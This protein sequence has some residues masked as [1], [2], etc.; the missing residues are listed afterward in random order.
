M[1]M[2]VARGRSDPWRKTGKISDSVMTAYA[3]IERVK[4]P[5]RHAYC[6]LIEHNGKVDIFTTYNN[7]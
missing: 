6:A 7:N 1:N 5:R 3:Q 2:L 4:L